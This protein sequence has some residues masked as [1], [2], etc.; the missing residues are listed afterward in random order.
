MILARRS[1][2][3][4]MSVCATYSIWTSHAKRAELCA[5][6]VFGP[7]LDWYDI[8]NFTP[9]EVWRLTGSQSLENYG[10]KSPCKLGLRGFRPTVA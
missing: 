5:G 8:S 1:K 10:Q 9:A 3:G 4:A 2:I 7:K 6:N